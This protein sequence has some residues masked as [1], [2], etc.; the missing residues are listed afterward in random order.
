M[1]SSTPKWYLGN[2][3]SRLKAYWEVSHLYHRG[4]L[5]ILVSKQ[6]IAA[7]LVI[8]AAES[9]PDGKAL[10]ARRAQN[11]LNLITKSKAA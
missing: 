8:K 5:D 2:T 9:H 6:C 1:T 4:G 3:P 7:L 10:L 11:L